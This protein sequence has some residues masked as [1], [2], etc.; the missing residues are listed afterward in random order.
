MQN[1]LNL[2]HAELAQRQKA[3]QARATLQNIRSVI[4]E[5][6]TQLQGIADSGS[7][8]TLDTEI[9]QALLD[10]WNVVKDAQAAMDAANIK[11][12]LDWSP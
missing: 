8:D 10:G 6:N 2:L 5:T 12:L 11:E 3:G 4:S 7:F 1:K 9:K